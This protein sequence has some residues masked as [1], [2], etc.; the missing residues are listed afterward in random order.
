MARRSK[1]LSV[2]AASM[3]LLVA[4]GDRNNSSEASE[5]TK[6]TNENTTEVSENSSEEKTTSIN[7]NETENNEIENS[8][9]NTEETE[10]TTKL[11]EV[12]PVIK[13]FLQN[14]LKTAK[15]G[16]TEGVPFE[17]GETILEEIIKDWGQP[18]T[19][20]SN[21]TDYIEYAEN[22]IVKYTFAVGRGDRIYDVRTFI[23]PD[24][25]FQLSDIS[26]GDIEKV[27][28]KP[29]FITTSGADTVLNYTV[30]KNTLKFVGPSKTKILHHISIFNQAASE[31][32]GGKG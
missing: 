19:A 7:N 32:M 11:K 23:S 9:S 25:S 8:T 10:T 29:D 12:D 18:T 3:L 30:G 16:M 22:D 1:M 31:P 15:N 4:C 27:V 14:Q 21:S 20:Y 13:D 26:F 17:S 6:A 24:E 5:T 28:G 2:F